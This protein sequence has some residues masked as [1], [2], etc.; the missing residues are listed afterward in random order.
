MLGAPGSGKGTQ[1]ER[2]ASYF[3]VPHLSTGEMLR[4]EVRRGSA[5]G[6]QVAATLAAG[7]LVS[8]E[9]IEDLLYEPFLSASRSGGFVLDG[10]P[11]TLHQAQRAF[12]IALEAGATLQ[13]VVHLDVPTSVLLERALSRGEGRADDNQ[14]T[15]RHRI[16][17]YDAETQP[18]VDYYAGR[19]ILVSVDGTG[20]PDDVFEA[21]L[22]RLPP[23]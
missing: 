18:L 9:V 20:S 15:V 6:K 11:R 21:I 12:E 2:L 3:G 13:A 17:V 4:S 7:D 23:P 16:E 22:K 19:G 8:D 5:L 1:A 14:A 10:F